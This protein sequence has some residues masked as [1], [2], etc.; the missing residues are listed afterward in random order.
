M[1]KKTKVWLIVIGAAL[2]SVMGCSLWIGIAFDEEAV[3]ARE[4]EQ[5]EAA[6]ILK[7]TAL[8][9]SRAFD[10]MDD[11]ARVMC[12]D[13]NFVKD[14]LEDEWK[15]Q[16]VSSHRIGGIGQGWVGNQGD[17]G[18]ITKSDFPRMYI[19]TGRGKMEI[20]GETIRPLFQETRQYNYNCTVRRSNVT[21]RGFD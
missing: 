8:A 13:K 3:A 14:S 10:S 7:A 15:E 5:A 4:A 6:R 20:A 9:E 16:N 12:G 11:W 21:D 19:F 2:L 17:D 18:R 1:R